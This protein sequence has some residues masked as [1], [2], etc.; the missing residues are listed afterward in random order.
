VIPR[1]KV[2]S[3][4]ENGFVIVS[5]L[6]FPGILITLYRANK[7]PQNLITELLPDKM[8]LRSA[9]GINLGRPE[10]VNRGSGNSGSI[11]RRDLNG[12]PATA[13]KRAN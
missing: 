9:K 6:S 1:V 8:A 10:V 12:L 5:N 2:K 3:S 4:P 11:S 13:L 7:D